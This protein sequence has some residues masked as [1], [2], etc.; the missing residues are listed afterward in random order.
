MQVFPDDYHLAT[1]EVY[2]NT[3]S[4]LQGAC[5]QPSLR[6]LPSCLRGRSP[7]AW[8]CSLAPSHTT[9]NVNVKNIIISLMNRLS[10]YAKE[11]PESMPKDVEMFPLFHKY[12]SKVIQGNAKMPLTDILA[13]QVIARSRV[14]SCSHAC[15]LCLC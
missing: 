8:S 11:S 14:Q 2:L 4:Q 3:C 10:N 13:L 6:P 7:S 1:L 9:E 15:S 12:S 5:L